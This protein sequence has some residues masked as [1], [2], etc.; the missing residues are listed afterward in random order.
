VEHTGWSLTAE[1]Y[2]AILWLAGTAWSGAFGLFV[3]LYA[4]PLMLPREAAGPV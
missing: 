2:L 1:H 4:R 3:L